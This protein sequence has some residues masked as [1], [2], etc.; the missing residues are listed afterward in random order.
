MNNVEKWSQA[1][2]NSL[3]TNVSPEEMLKRCEA[4]SKAWEEDTSEGFDEFNELSICI[5]EPLFGD[6][7]DEAEEAYDEWC[8]NEQWPG[9]I[10]EIWGDEWGKVAELVFKHGY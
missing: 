6:D 10:G 9:W 8:D 2:S 4:Y 3:I 5:V 1:V 7:D